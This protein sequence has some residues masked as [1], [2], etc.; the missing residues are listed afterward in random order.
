MTQLDAD[1]DPG[2]V[3]VADENSSAPNLYHVKYDVASSKL[4]KK[5]LLLGELVVVTEKC[6]G[7]SA[8]YVYHNDRMWCSSHSFWKKEFVDHSH[9]T[10]AS[11]LAGIR[12]GKERK[13]LDLDVAGDEAR[14][15][16]IVEKL[17]SK[18]S[19]KNIFWKVLDA[20]PELREYCQDNPGHIV[21]G[22]VYGTQDLKYGCGAGEVKFVA[23][24]V[25]EG[26]HWLEP[27]QFFYNC[28]YWQI[29]RVPIVDGG[30]TEE[31]HWTGKMLRYINGVEF[32]YDKV[33][34]LAEKDS[35]LCP[36][37]I[38]EGVVV[39]PIKERKDRRGNRVQYK[40]ISQRYTNRLKGNEA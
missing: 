23:F 9:V 27:E 30:E 26:N 13:G 16:E 32:N 38:G 17:K 14:A 4:A 1:A 6:H 29:P 40:Y 3:D 7:M 2:K 28:D 5:N 10:V 36:G 20:T 21:Y 24:D 15:V 39:R 31:E 8:R 11:V 34:E 25:L 18:G 19:E 35:I 22:E 33:C 37:Q 12:K